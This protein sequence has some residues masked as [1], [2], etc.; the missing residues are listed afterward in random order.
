MQ[1]FSKTTVVGFLKKSKANSG[2]S[3]HRIVDI[4]VGVLLTL[5]LNMTLYTGKIKSKYSKNEKEMQSF[6][7]DSFEQFELFFFFIS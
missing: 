6:A 5:N 3:K 2:F 4:F 1:R 7:P